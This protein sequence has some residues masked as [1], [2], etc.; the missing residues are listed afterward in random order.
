M[1]KVSSTDGAKRRGKIDKNSNEVFRVSKYGKEHSYTF[2]PS[3]KPASKAQNI[4]RKNFGKINAL[5]NGI[6]ADP[7]QETEW[8]ARMTEYNR[9]RDLSDPSQKRYESLRQF[10]FAMVR[11]QLES[12]PAL[13]RRKTQL[14]FTLPKDIKLQIKPFAELTAAEV[15]EILKARCEVFLCEQ[16]ICYLDQDNLD[17]RATHFSLRRKGL[18][19][20]YARLFKDTE[21]GAYRV[22]R[23]LCKERGNGYGRFLMEQIILNAR[24]LAAKKLTLQAQMPVVSFYEQ[25]GFVTVG[26]PF[27]E[28]DLAHIKMVLDLTETTK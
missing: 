13:R 2:H 7:V 23:M 10:V 24:Q 20:A 4:N 19:I 15:Y 1:A 6:V 5:V 28:A 12:K 9:Q 3:D 14:P 11:E 16:R 27:H 21:R 18:V 26:E 17:Y 22:G 8:R 25:F